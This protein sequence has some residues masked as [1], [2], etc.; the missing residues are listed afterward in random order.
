M[1]TETFVRV[2]RPDAP[3]RLVVDM[4]YSEPV[5]LIPARPDGDVTDPRTVIAL[6]GGARISRAALDIR[7]A[8]RGWL[9]KERA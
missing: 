5:H 2:H 1:S 7:A 4:R 6:P 8:E 3:T 9:I